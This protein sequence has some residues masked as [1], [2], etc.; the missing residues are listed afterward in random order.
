[1]RE[2]EREENFNTLTWQQYA[3][4]PIQMQWKILISILID[5]IYIIYNNLYLYCLTDQIQDIHD[6]RAQ[7]QQGQHYGER[8]TISRIEEAKSG[9]Y[10]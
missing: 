8:L 3:L 10:Y 4:Y 9:G 2:R 5:W 1:M 6:Q 7:A